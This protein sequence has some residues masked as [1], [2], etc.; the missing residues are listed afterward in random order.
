MR[1]IGGVESMP[2]IPCLVHGRGPSHIQA[3][4]VSL[5]MGAGMGFTTSHPLDTGFV[6]WLFP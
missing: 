5:E 3:R 6:L 2:G 1:L 4:K